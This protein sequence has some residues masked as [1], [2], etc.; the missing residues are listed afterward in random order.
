MMHNGHRFKEGTPQ[1]IEA[2]KEVQQI[3]L[4]GRRG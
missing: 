1:A 4:G 3:Y 2:D